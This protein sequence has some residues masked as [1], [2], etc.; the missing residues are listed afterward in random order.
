MDDETSSALMFGSSF[1]A[2]AAPD[3]WFL[4]AYLWAESEDAEL[5][6]LCRFPPSQIV[7][8]T[9]T[10][11]SG[12]VRPAEL[13]QRPEPT[14]E[15]GGH[16][17]AEAPQSV[18]GAQLPQHWSETSGGV[19]VTGLLIEPLQAA[20]LDVADGQRPAVVNLKQTASAAEQLVVPKVSPHQRNNSKHGVTELLAR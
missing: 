19:L 20:V 2:P 11:E 9:E 13:P 5:K 4:T 17:V 10:S 3:G 16:V 1:S 8:C 12:G 18:E 15:Q 7:S 6:Q 14:L